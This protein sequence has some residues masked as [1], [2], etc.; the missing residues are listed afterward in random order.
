MKY[1]IRKMELL[2]KMKLKVKARETA[3]K[4]WKVAH[5]HYTT[6]MKNKGE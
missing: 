1:R 2:N 4:Y 5:D 6:N 3:L